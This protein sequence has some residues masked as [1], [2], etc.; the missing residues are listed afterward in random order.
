MRQQEAKLNDGT[1]VREGDIVGFI[2]SDRYLIKGEISRRPN[3][4]LYFHNITYEIS[5][6]HNLRLIKRGNKNKIK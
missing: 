4:T 2:G 3:G 6:Y 1:I 5:D